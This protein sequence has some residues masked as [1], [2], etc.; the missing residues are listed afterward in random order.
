MKLKEV[1]D[2]SINEEVLKN[3]AE[4]F[5][6]IHIVIAP[7]ISRIIFKIQDGPIQEV[8]DNGCQIDEIGKVWLE[9][10]RGFN[11]KF[12]CRENSLSI[13]KIEEALMW[14][15]KRTQNREERGVEGRNL[16]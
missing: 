3:V 8:G 14:Q 15:A 13:T 5:D 9:I 10:L 6:T 12:P 11:K 7:M 16:A 1:K 2:M 4:K